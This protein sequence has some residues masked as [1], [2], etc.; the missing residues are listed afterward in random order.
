MEI[1]KM[2]TKAKQRNGSDRPSF[3]VNDAKNKVN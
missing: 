2:I 1:L 3:N